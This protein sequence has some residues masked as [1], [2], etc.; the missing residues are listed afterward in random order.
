VRGAGDDGAVRLLAALAVLLAFKGV[1]S[2]GWSPDA[3]GRLLRTLSNREP[4]M[5]A[6]EALTA[7]YYE[8]LINEGSRVSWMNRFSTES[9]GFTFED[10][11]QPDRR[12]TGDFMVYELVPDSDTPDY[13]DERSRYRLKTNS[14]G[15]ADRE[16]ARQKPPGVH[17][18]ALLGDSIAR[19][20]GAPY[21]GNYESLLEEKLNEGA[22]AAGPRVEILNFAVGGYNVT[23]MLES[24]FVKATPYDPDVYVVALTKLSV[25][26]RWG[27]HLA[28]LLDAGIDVKYDY[29]RSVVREAGLD[30]TDPIGVTHAKLARFRIP[31][32]RWVL[33]ELQ[34]HAASHDAEVV[35]ALVPSAEDADIL[36]EEFLG[37]REVVD[38]LGIPVIDLLDTFERVDYA[39]YRVAAHDGHP[40]AAGHRLLFERLYERLAADARLSRAFGG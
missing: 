25:Y 31:T 39:T 20:E 32:I 3:G 2:A 19:G 9:A 30:R 7:G 12:E 11:R 33:A 14:A 28:L 17:R 10:R 23:Q 29:L 36:R 24:A 5:E 34:R 18:V 4:N 40:N 6:R 1:H 26:R 15:L 27:E 13:R 38:G 21:L 8:G 37:V 22:A 35:V 16:Y